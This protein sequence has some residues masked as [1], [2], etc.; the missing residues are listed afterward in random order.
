ALA[1]FAGKVKF[2]PVNIDVERMLA[3]TYQV[4]EV[5]RIVVFTDGVATASRVGD[6]ES[7][8]LLQFFAAQASPETRQAY[9]KPPQEF[10]AKRPAGASLKTIGG[11]EIDR[12]GDGIAYALR[13]S[14][15]LRRLEETKV[16]PW[17]VTGSA[18]LSLRYDPK[19]QET[20]WDVAY[21][22]EITRPAN[23]NKPSA[24]Q[25]AGTELVEHPGSHV[26][27]KLDGEQVATLPDPLMLQAAETAEA[28][29]KGARLGFVEVSRRRFHS[30]VA[31]EYLQS[32]R[33]GDMTPAQF[34]KLFVDGKA[35][36]FSITVDHQ[37]V[38]LCE[39]GIEET[40]KALAYLKAERTYAWRKQNPVSPPR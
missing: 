7:N 12:D 32:I 20:I 3:Q 22:Q 11:W 13:A 35:V 34:E 29:D 37:T 28:V 33:F 25:S 27:M 16:G 8:A 4:T 5:P 30:V 38:V 6:A 23:D 10:E 2:S 36:Q 40:Q 14:R 17:T 18:A 39:I 1:A 15:Y 9:Q 24:P 19:K 31:N 26:I 21:A